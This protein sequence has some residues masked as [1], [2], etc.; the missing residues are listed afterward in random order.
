MTH[1]TGR[2]NRAAPGFIL[3]FLMAVGKN[4]KG[5]AF[6]SIMNHT[7]FEVWAQ[8]GC[9]DEDPL[10]HLSLGAQ[11][12][13]GILTSIQ[14]FV[15]KILL[16]QGG[17]EP[18]SETMLPLSTPSWMVCLMPVNTCR[19]AEAAKTSVVLSVERCGLHC[20]TGWFMAERREH[21]GSCGVR[22]DRGST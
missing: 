2:A 18:G 9:T 21:T 22:V 15:L 1:T 14:Q 7:A 10:S 6:S 12:P 11:G 4:R 8:E 13:C 17:P 16:C 5:T 3:A 19:G 20:S